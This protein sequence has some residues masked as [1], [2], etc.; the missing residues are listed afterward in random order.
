MND[1][2]ERTYLYESKFNDSRKN[3]VNLLLLENEQNVCIKNLKSLITFI[4]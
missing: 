2:E 1:R 4:I 3:Q